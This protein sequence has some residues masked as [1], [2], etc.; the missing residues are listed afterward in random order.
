MPSATR[1]A[2]HNL[3][4]RRWEVERVW[5]SFI[6]GTNLQN[7]PVTIMA[8]I[9]RKRTKMGRSTRERLEV[10]DKSELIDRILQLEVHNEQ[11]KLL[12]T[13]NTEPKPRKEETPGKVRKSFDF[14]RCH[15]R[16]ILLKFYYLGWDYHGFTVQEDNCDTIE[17]HLFAALRKSC[18][19]ESRESANYHRCGRTDKGVSSFSQVIS[20]DVRSRLEPEN[21]S[22]LSDELPYCKILN[23]LLPVNIRC[24]AWC[25]VVSGFSARFDCKYRRYKYF[26]PRGSLDIDA[27]DKA[28]KYVVGDHDFRN[29]C[30]MDVANGVINFKRTIM[31]ARVFVIDRSSDKSIGYDMCELEITSQ[32]FLWHQI[33]CLM[34]I[35][36]LVGQK[37]E[38][39]EIILKLL[40]IETCP[41]K[42]Q[43]NM[44][45][46]I[47]LNLWY[48]DYKDV[49]WFVDENELLNTIKILQQDWALNTIKSTMIKNML[50]EL[51]NFVSCVNTNFQSDCLLLGIQSKIYQPLMKREMCGKYINFIKNLVNLNSPIKQISSFFDMLFKNVSLYY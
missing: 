7:L 18:C 43:Y 22:N 12:I 51:K 1:V 16:H 29:I 19:I 41:Q 45:H 10:L 15:K 14:S 26:F 33:R 4:S 11:L 21:Q 37:K 8:K 32:A 38:E 2:Q 24:V 6:D 50:T 25:P 40:D 30:K 5:F 28:A 46:H 17:H 34:G 31:D 27:M 42:P 13:K 48:C 23:R 9:L 47:P 44:A 36:L 20:L 35:L 39:P 3:R 49:K